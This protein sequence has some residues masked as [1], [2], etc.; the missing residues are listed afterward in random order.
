MGD[1]VLGARVGPDDGL[2]E[3]LARLAAPCDGGLALVGD[4][5]EAK[6]ATF[7]DAWEG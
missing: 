3:R 1:D 7:G 6:D 5:C 2:A 4:T